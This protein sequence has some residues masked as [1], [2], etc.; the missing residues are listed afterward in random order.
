MLGIVRKGTFTRVTRKLP[1]PSKVTVMKRLLIPPNMA[2]G[3]SPHI[4]SSL[5]SLQC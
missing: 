1:L 3:S 5:A 2:T 4:L